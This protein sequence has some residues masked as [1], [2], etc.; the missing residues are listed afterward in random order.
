MR[1]WFAAWFL[2]HC[3]TSSFTTFS[4]YWILMSSLSWLLS[5]ERTLMEE[6]NEQRFNHSFQ[7]SGCCSIFF[8]PKCE[9]IITFFPLICNSV[10]PS[11]EH[12]KPGLMQESVPCYGSKTLGKEGKGKISREHFCYF[13]F[14]WT[15]WSQTFICHKNFPAFTSGQ[16][17]HHVKR[18]DSETEHGSNLWLQYGG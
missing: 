9:I 6:W 2:S 12:I 13:A 18:I 7:E 5:L 1:F 4:T 15:F 14:H 10:S 3:E 17:L 11:Q 16:L 8:W